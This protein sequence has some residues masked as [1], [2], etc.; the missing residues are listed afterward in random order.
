MTWPRARIGAKKHSTQA[1]SRTSALLGV[2]PPPASVGAIAIGPE[3]TLRARA[4]QTSHAAEV[5]PP[6]A[7]VPGPGSALAAALRRALALRARLGAGCR[8]MG[9][10]PDRDAQ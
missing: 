8:R 5:A 7:A 3:S 10:P 6:T 9:L 2:H 4:L 1:T